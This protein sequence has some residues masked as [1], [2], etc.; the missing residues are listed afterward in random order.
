MTHRFDI[1]HFRWRLAETIAWC[2]PLVSLTDFRDSLRTRELLPRYL[3]YRRPYPARGLQ[4]DLARYEYEPHRMQAIVEALAEERA[5][6]LRADRRYPTDPA[7]HL[8]RG[9]LLL[10]APHESF[11]DGVS[12]VESSGFFDEC[13]VPPWDTWV[14][15]LSE[16][17]NYEEGFRREMLEHRA[18]WSP[19]PV[20]YLIS[21]VPPE[22]KRPADDGIEI[23]A[24]GCIL[25]AMDYSPYRHSVP[26]FIEALQALE[27]AG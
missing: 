23:N 15:Y 19:E 12:E 11:P 3:V 9:S 27:L 16:E 6:R 5:R 1:R 18:D 2:A 14:C 25:W 17:V 4:V 20:S 13:D 22:W 7:G 24:Y 10:S 26:R 8:A 21:W